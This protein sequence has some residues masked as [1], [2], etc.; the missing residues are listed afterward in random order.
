[1]PWKDSVSVLIAYALKNNV[2][3][4]TWQLVTGNKDSI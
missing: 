4:E 3:S 2:N 1:M